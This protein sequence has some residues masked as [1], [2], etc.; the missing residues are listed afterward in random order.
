MLHLVV[1]AAALALSSTAMAVVETFDGFAGGT[2]LSSIG[3]GGVW[4][5][6]GS[7]AVVAGGGVAGS[8]GIGPETSSSFIL[9]WQGQPFQW[10]ALASND[11]VAIGLD[12]QSSPAG[13]FDDDRVGWTTNAAS[14]A[15][16]ASQLCLQID[17]AADGGMVCYWDTNRTVLNPLDGIKASTWYRFQ[18]RF[19]K[20]DDTRAAI[21]GVLTELDAAGNPTNAPYVGTIAD[22]SAAPYSVPASRFTSAYQYPS[23]KNYRN[24]AGNADNASF[25]IEPG[26]A[27]YVVVIS[28]DGMGTAYVKPLLQAG[29]ANE[30]VN[31]KRIMNEAAGTLNARDDY[32]Y[33]VTLPNHVTMMTSR[34][35]SGAAGHGWTSNTDPGT[36]TLE[37]NKGSYVDSG[38]GVAHDAGLRTGI[39]SGKSKF[40]LFQQSYSA[41]TGAADTNGVDNGRDKIDYDLISNG[42]SAANITANFTNQMTAAPCHFA[43]LH[44]QDPDATGH[45]S[46]WSTDPASAFATT[47]KA[48]DNAI[49]SILQMIENSP[50]LTGRTAVILT[51]DHGGHGTTHGDTTNPLDYTIPFYVWGPGVTAGADLYTINPTTREAPGASVNPPYTGPQPVRDGDAANLALSLLGLPPIPASMINA[52]QD[53]AVSGDVQPQPPEVA[54]TSPA[55]GTTQASPV[56]IDA[57]ATDADGS[58]TNVQFFAGATW[59]G[60]D[61]TSPY[62]VVWTDAPAGSYALTAVA[63]DDDGLCTTSTAVSITVSAASGGGF[64]AYNDCSSSASTPANTTQYRG[65][66]TTSGY[67]KDFDTGTV[68]PVTLTI[69]PNQVAYDGTGGPMPNSGTDA[70]AV[71]N[72]KVV[73]DDAIW[74]NNVTTWWMDATFTGLDPEKEYEFVAS[75]NRG[76]TG[77]D[78]NQRMSKFT[79]SGADSCIQ[80]GTPGVTVHSNESVTF[81]SGYNTVNGYVARWTHIRCGADGT[82]KVRVEDGGST[83]KKGYAFDGIMLRETAGG[84][85][86]PEV[87]ITSPADAASVPLDFTIEATAWDDGSVTNLAFLAD[88]A[89]LGY[90]AEAPY[91]WTWENAPTGLHE[92]FA[93]A[94]DDEGLCTTSAAVSVTVVAP[95]PPTV[96]VTSPAEGA[97]VGTAFTIQAAASDVVG[98]VT[99]VE[100]LADGALLGS[101]ATAPY[102]FAWSGAPVGVCTLAAV[103]WDNDG[104]CTTSAPVNVTIVYQPPAVSISGPAQGATVGTTFTINATATDTD[105][106][107]ARVEFYLDGAL[108]GT[109]SATP[110][111]QAV[112]GVA[113]GAHALKAVAWDST[114]LCTTSATVNVTAA[115]RLP[116]V[117]ITSPAE[118]ATVRLGFNILATASD[119]D[120]S[121]A[122]VAFYGDGNLLGTDSSS[123]F[124]QMWADSAAGEHPIFAV[125]TDN[126][127][128]VSTSAV[129]NV[130][131]SASVGFTAYNDCSSS[132]STPANTTQWRSNGTTSGLLTDFDSGAS[133]PVT[134]ALAAQNVSYDVST[135]AGMS[136]AGTDC[137][138]VFNGKVPFDDCIAYKTGAGAWWATATFSGLDPEKEYEFV[139]SCNRNGSA[140]TGRF[141]MFTISGVD[142]CLQAS[143]PGVDVLSNESVRFCTGYNTVNGYVARW[144]RIKCGADGTFVVRV[145]DGAGAEAGKSYAFDGIMLRE[146]TAPEPVVVGNIAIDG[147]SISLSWSGVP[148]KARIEQTESL[149]EPS[150]TTVPDATNLQGGTHT[151]EID[152][153][154]PRRFYRVVAE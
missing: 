146:T 41:T 31:I 75:V 92:L 26:K 61:A 112:S 4:W 62:S 74:Y 79:I 102:A 132:S 77:G 33:A 51:A 44:Y 40:S 29:L 101:D 88:G 137:H 117:A 139:T 37:S 52:E 147:A 135:G 133:L 14:N 64:T 138:T 126:D 116:S 134:I 23:F 122:S 115:A 78:Y 43:F 140:Y 10:S 17:N 127:G 68:L 152:G 131:A 119:P 104:M 6:G 21:E 67:L 35:V 151:F 80:A 100:F 94:W 59:I 110:F 20:L 28:V 19:T 50:T 16:S 121:V 66:S 87:S 96:S 105:G 70:Y 144:T 22:S 120:G 53:L 86:G 124:S 103:A 58:V 142:A 56:T 89:V 83:V 57:T 47:L 84:P 73:F 99:N 65:N 12:F 98:A 34:G 114:G 9:N 107:V 145:E 24:L 38:F 125:A 136:A 118:G 30:L 95:Q 128:Y 7:H 36:A 48:V 154:A 60:D 108:R 15:S 91:A 150:W 45:A 90:D 82:F 8:N 149:S 25:A 141:S 1:G 63:W 106:T 97:T 13:T 85:S 76:G 130:T 81:C 72:G 143:T 49:G 93:V 129:V 3:G 27:D 18:V 148:G 42:I 54:I 123:P 11:T 46:G 55:N 113:P 111:S 32:N 153:S 39:W 69:T 2:L 5:T 71:F 109:D